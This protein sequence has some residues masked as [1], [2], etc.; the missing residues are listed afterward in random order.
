[1]NAPIPISREEGAL[2]SA[3]SPSGVRRRLLRAAVPALASRLLD[4]P[5]R[6]GF[7]LL[8]A[9]GLGMRGA[10]DFYIAFSLMVALAGFGRLGI[11]RALIREV[12]IAIGAGRIGLARRLIFRAFAL[13]GLLSGGLSLALIFVAEPLARFGLGRPELG[14]A[15]ALGALAILPQNL[16][17]VI[18]GA[19]AGVRRVGLSQMIYSWLWPALFCLTAPL[20]GLAVPMALKL[21]ALCFTVAMLVG[22]ICLVRVFPRQAPTLFAGPLPPLL[23]PGLS[24]FT[25][26][27]AQLT[28]TSAPVLILGLVADSAAVGCFALAWRIALLANIV[29]SGVAAMASPRFAALQ[30][31]GDRPGLRRAAALSSGLGFALA[32]P[33]LLAMLALPVPLLGLFGPG[34]EQAASVL[35][36]LALGQLAAAACTALPELL[37]MAGQEASLRKINA[38]T[39]VLATVGVALLAP[40]W[41]AEGAALA[42]ALALAAAGG[43]AALAAWHRLGVAPWRDLGRELRCWK[44]G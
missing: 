7:H 9:A 20:L 17:A 38:L 19:L 41:G 16:G 22:L 35:R 23:W 44:R 11:D 25:L 24:L 40:R 3:I 43:G 10:G 5:S 15:L 6:Y 13:V 32:L 36:L 30:D 33:V 2:S 12:A 8:I 34:F 4:L 14:E 27:L 26:E 37:G 42:T 28:L 1:M 29:I 31:Q 21:I 18:A 39:I